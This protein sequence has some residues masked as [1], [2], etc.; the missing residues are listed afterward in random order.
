MSA[1]VTMNERSKAGARG[2]AAAAAPART[3]GR[4]KASPRFYVCVGIL[5][6][7][8]MTMQTAATLL[9]QTFRK[10][11][12]PL[13]RGLAAAD[14]RKLAPEYALHPVPPAPLSPEMLESLGTTEYLTWR[15]IDLS[16]PDSDPTKAASVFVTY[17]TG[18]PDMVPHVPDEC[19]KA[20]GYECSDARTAAVVVPDGGGPNN[21]IPVRV[22]QFDA[23]SGLR[24][25]FQAARQRGPT[26]MYFFLCNGRYATTRDEVRRLQMN[27]FDK[28]AYY[29]KIEVSFS[30]SRFAAN[31]GPEESLA[32]L[33][34]LLRKLL[35]ILRNDHFQDWESVS[36]GGPIVA[37]SPQP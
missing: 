36:Q 9:G 24:D 20:S 11:A 23:P 12:L 10:E 3:A 15:I 16:K 28:Y 7:A 14:P 25:R 30:D 8:A 5:I 37:P 27:L 2:S 32:A 1:P 33:Q 19:M 26:V 17:Y 29:A 34:P 13:K 31:A 35:P 18:K 4:S 21:Q 22:L 6:V